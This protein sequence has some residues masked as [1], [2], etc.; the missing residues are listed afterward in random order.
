[1]NYNLSFQELA[2]LQKEVLSKQLP[3]TLAKAKKQVESLKNQSAS[4]SKKQ[5]G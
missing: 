2:R 1:M 4:K 3:T 5:R